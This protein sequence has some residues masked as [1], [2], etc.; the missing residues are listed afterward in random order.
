MS[1][2][3]CQA[4]IDQRQRGNTVKEYLR[5]WTTNIYS[6]YEDEAEEIYH[7]QC[8]SQ[9]HGCAQEW[10]FIKQDHNMF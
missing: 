2:Q 1:H 6:G 8:Q 4:V 10:S 3:K 7:L 9:D 5:R